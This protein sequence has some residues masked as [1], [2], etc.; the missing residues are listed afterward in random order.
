MQVC[1]ESRFWHFFAEARNS[2][3][4]SGVNEMETALCDRSTGFG[5]LSY[6]LLHGKGKAV[7]ANQHALNPPDSGH[8]QWGLRPELNFPLAGGGQMIFCRRFAL[9]GLAFVRQDPEPQSKTRDCH[10]F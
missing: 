4:P 5:R 9:D 1:H 7:G 2:H 6:S 3:L 10:L 8:A